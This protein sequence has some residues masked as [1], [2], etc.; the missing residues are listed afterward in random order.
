MPTYV[1]DIPGGHGKVPIGLPAVRSDGAGRHI[2]TDPH[3]VEHSYVD[4][5]EEPSNRSGRA[6]E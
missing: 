1:L 3:G 6:V 4:V 5:L 2:V